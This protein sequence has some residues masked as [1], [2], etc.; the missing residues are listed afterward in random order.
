MIIFPGIIV[1]GGKN[2]DDGEWK[3]LASVEVIRED[4]TTCSLPDLPEP[5]EEHSQSGLLSC[6]GYHDNVRTTCTEFAS[7]EWTPSHNLTEDRKT[8]TS[9]NAPDGIILLG[10]WSS[11]NTS[12]LLSSYTSSTTLSFDLT[13]KTRYYNY[14]ESNMQ[15]IALSFIS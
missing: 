15:D 3:T 11:P 7:G 2:D 9:W 6:G 10:G 8:H 14:S 1:S 4:G 13:Y 5:R 12:E